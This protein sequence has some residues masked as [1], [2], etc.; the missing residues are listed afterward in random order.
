MSLQGGNPAVN[1]RIQWVIIAVSLFMIISLSHSVVDLWGRRS[2]VGQE[3]ARLK[4]T[5]KRHDEL[6]KRLQTVNTE[7]FVEQEARER[8]GLA[9]EG[10]TVIIMNTNP[11]PGGEQPK[12]EFGEPIPNWKQWWQVFF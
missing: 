2:I 7:T 9:K 3:E 5:Q 6:T 10:D 11:L 1:T 4:E 12:D 8:L